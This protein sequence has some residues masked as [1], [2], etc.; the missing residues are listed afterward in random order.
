[1]GQGI[2]FS[3]VSPPKA[4]EPGR[5][6]LF[7]RMEAGGFPGALAR[8]VARYPEASGLEEI[9]RATA[10]QVSGIAAARSR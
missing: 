8:L 10:V 1:M 2:Q 6:T 4:K 5:P 3:R 7:A 9:S